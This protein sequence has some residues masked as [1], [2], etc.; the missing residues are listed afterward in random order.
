MKHY[1]IRAIT[2]KQLIKLLEKDGWEIKR[3]ARHG[4]ALAK[5]IGDRT[6]VTIVPDATVPLPQG[7]LKA[8]LGPKQTCLG[9]QGLQRLIYRK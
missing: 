1:K 8:I 6:R 2:G 4:I 5:K 3:R 9:R 7:T